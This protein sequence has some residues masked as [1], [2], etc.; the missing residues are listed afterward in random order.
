M[1]TSNPIDISNLESSFEMS[2]TSAHGL[3]TK[4]VNDPGSCAPNF[5]RI[6][7]EDRKFFKGVAIEAHDKSHCSTEQLLTCIGANWTVEREEHYRKSKG[8][9][10]P[11][12]LH[13][14]RSDNGDKLGS[15]SDRREPLDPHHVVD[16]FREFC[17]SSDKELSLDV[18]GF[19]SGTNKIY[20]ASKLTDIGQ[21]LTHVG[22]STDHWMI[23]T[24]DYMQPRAISTYVWHNELVCTNGMTRK[25]TE[26]AHYLTHRKF[27]TYDE[28][29]PYLTSALQE[30]EGYNL[31][32]DRLINT[33]LDN[34]TARNVIRKFF[35]DE[36]GL[37][38]MNS[39]SK[40]PNVRRLERIYERDLTGG[41]LETRKGNAFRL[42]Q[43]FTEWTSHERK[44]KS[45]DFR[46]SQKLGG[47]LAR[48][49]RRATN[50]ILETI[51]A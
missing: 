45:D 50:L 32:K 13:W 46:F 40:F 9:S 42:Q 25:I 27:R 4:P 39:I 3:C 6:T 1:T 37:E 8:R 48:I 35:R 31:I 33:P 7:K 26:D 43:A 23:M 21:Q 2:P 36:E 5:Q 14:Y 30:C 17:N 38:N 51:N 18:I 10:F 49:D 24:V 34:W 12:I 22:D 28:I 29:K 15:F 19:E 11:N 44:S 47:D 41:N 20:A 16:Y